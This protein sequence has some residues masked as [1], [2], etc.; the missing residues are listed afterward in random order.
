MV[1]ELVK[2][3]VLLII[4]VIAAYP[5]N[6]TLDSLRNVIIALDSSVSRLPVKVQWNFY[7]T[8]NPDSLKVL[9]YEVYYCAGDDSSKFPFH[10]GCSYTDTINGFTVEEWRAGETFQ[11]SGYV[12]NKHHQKFWRFGVIGKTKDGVRTKMFFCK[13]YL[14]ENLK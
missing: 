6:K 2:I 12:T 8:N 9:W 4:F 5:Q 3:F 13:T 10:L 14:N 1:S 7:P 11:N